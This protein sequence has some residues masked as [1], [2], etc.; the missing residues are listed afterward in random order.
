MSSEPVV[1]LNNAEKEAES[2]YVAPEDIQHHPAR[3]QRVVPN[4]ADRLLERE[5]PD[6]R[7]LGE[8]PGEPSRRLRGT[9][10]TVGSVIGRAI[11]TARDLPRRV[12]EMR[13]RFTVIRGRT[14]QNAASTAEELKETARQK[15]RVA[16]TRAQ[17]YAHEYPLQFIGAVGASCVVLGMIL[18]V[19]RSSRYD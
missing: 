11:N 3:A 14:Q 6:S 19:W 5:Y 8:I 2:P 18:R 15:A 1:P 4:R 12:A 10:E 17:H 9:A 16:Q 7:P 13:E